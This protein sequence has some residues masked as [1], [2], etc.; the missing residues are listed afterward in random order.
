MQN[1]HEKAERAKIF[2]PF[3]SLKGYRD[4]I[5]SKERVVVK[6]KLLSEDDCEVLDRKLRQVKKGM[7]IKIVYYDQMDYVEV[8][9]MVSMIDTENQRVLQIVD[10]RINIKDII[11][12]QGAEIQE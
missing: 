12:L 10:K 2:L 9:G 11:E 4:I 8:Q 6:R 3:D 1:N 7:M 5:K